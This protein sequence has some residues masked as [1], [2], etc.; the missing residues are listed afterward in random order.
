MHPRGGSRRSG[1]SRLPP[2]CAGVAQG[3][4]SRRASSLEQAQDVPECRAR[5]H[6]AEPQRARGAAR[7]GDRRGVPRARL[8]GRRAGGRRG[9]RRADRVRA[10]R[11]VDNKTELQEALARSGNQ[12]QYEVIGVEGPP[13][14]RP[15]VCV[16][17]DRGRAGRDRQRLDEEG[18]R[19]GSR[20][21]GAP[22]DGDV[23]AAG[24]SDRPLPG[25]ALIERFRGGE[26]EILPS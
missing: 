19:A 6:L 9:L 15:F 5:P 23:V 1:R 13:H 18:R 4:R 7:G 11:Q 12:V 3:A 22:G 17:R 20:P 24:L 16:G 21:S 26:S 2:S 10:H 14:D 8:R 25:R